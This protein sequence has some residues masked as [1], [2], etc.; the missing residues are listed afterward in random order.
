MDTQ[1]RNKPGNVSGDRTESYGRT[2]VLWGCHDAVPAE[3]WLVL[4]SGCRIIGSIRSCF[5]RQKCCCEYF[6]NKTFQ[7]EPIIGSSSKLPTVSMLKKCYYF[8]HFDVSGLLAC[9]CCACRIQYDGM[10]ALHCLLPL[11]HYVVVFPCRS[12][13]TTKLVSL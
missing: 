3:V 8:F 6:G 5:C 7:S 12:Y 9:V 11:L 10:A 13:V 2:H 1:S 4:K